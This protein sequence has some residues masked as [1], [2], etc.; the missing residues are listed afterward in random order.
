ML[1]PLIHTY[2]SYNALVCSVF[3]TMLMQKIFSDCMKSL[4]HYSHPLFFH[5][6]STNSFIYSPRRNSWGVMFMSWSYS[7]ILAATFIL[8][9]VWTVD[10]LQNG[11]ACQE[12]SFFMCKFKILIFTEFSIKTCESFQKKK[13]SK[14]EGSVSNYAYSITQTEK[15]SLYQQLHFW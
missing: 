6:F 3:H 13:S 8:W 2:F 12:A 4:G 10:R 1:K 15:D 11:I 9:V 7:L 5:R 14:K